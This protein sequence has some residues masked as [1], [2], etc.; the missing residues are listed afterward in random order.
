M[1]TSTFLHQRAA[2]LRRLKLLGG[3]I[4]PRHRVDGEYLERILDD[5]QNP[6]REYLLW[7]NEFVG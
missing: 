6:A 3:E 2:R 1:G 5:K 7:H 4:A